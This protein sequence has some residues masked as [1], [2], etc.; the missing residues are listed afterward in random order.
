MSSK[1]PVPALHVC[2]A[3][4]ITL[5]DVVNTMRWLILYLAAT[6]TGLSVATDAIGSSSIS[7]TVSNTK[8]LCC[9]SKL[10]VK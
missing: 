4:N 9:W 1:K 8:L 2:T 6:H 7:T 10:Y 5:H 3:H